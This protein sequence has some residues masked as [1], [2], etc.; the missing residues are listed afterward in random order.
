[1]A[2]YHLHSAVRNTKSLRR[3]HA[4]RTPRST[5]LIVCEG[6]TEEIYF[7]IVHSHYKLSTVV[8]APASTESAPIQVVQ[9]AKEQNDKDGGYDKIFCVFDRDDHASFDQ[10]LEEIDNL[11]SRKTKPIPIVGIISV[12]CFEMWL[13]LHF[14]KTD[15][16]F[17]RCSDVIN[18]LNTH[19]DYEKACPRAFSKLMA[20]L[21]EALNNAAW[22]EKNAA[23]NGRN[24]FTLIHKVLHHLQSAAASS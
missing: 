15:A 14:K 2:G 10:A 5:T 8:I 9:H 12:P 1:M 21:K 23:L 22:L 7:T 24:P 3:K 17:E 18:R 20:R 13:L 4:G 16:P 6:E 11:S 19:I